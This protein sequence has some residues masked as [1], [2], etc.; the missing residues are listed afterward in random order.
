[1]WVQRQFFT[2]SIEVVQE[3]SG[4]DIC[5]PVL[6][7]TRYALRR[8]DD[9]TDAAQVFTTPEDYYRV[10]FLAVLDAASNSLQQGFE[11]V[12]WDYLSKAESA[13]LVKGASTTVFSNFCKSDLNPER[14]QLYMLRD[15]I[16]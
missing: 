8:I 3:A 6:P 16:D 1:M 4:L 5:E 15:L 11:S 14:M 2:F 13:L 12:T 9:H 10:L 7:R